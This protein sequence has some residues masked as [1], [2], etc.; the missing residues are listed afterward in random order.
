M[1][2]MSSSLP[3]VGCLIGPK[4][5]IHITCRCPCAIQTEWP[6]AL[7]LIHSLFQGQT[8]IHYPKFFLKQPDLCPVELWCAYTLTLT[9]LTPWPILWEDSKGK[10]E[11]NITNNKWRYKNDKSLCLLPSFTWAVL[12]LRDSS[13]SLEVIYGS[14]F[15]SFQAELVN[16]MSKSH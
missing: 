12:D 11:G 7:L 2:E 14:S 6:P 8:L 15:I 13:R 10:S 1:R 5:Q 4:H 16:S 3:G 9:P